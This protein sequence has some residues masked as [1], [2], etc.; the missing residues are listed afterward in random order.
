MGILN[1]V[2]G[3]V[4]LL[5]LVQGALKAK[6]LIQH[7]SITDMAKVTKASMDVKQIVVSVEFERE[8]VGQYPMDMSS[9]RVPEGFVSPGNQPQLSAF[10]RENMTSRLQKRDPSLDSWNRPYT[11]C[12][13]LV[14]YWVYSRGPDERDTI[15]LPRARNPEGDI[16]PAVYDYAG[17]V[18][19]YL[20]EDEIYVEQEITR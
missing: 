2:A 1:K 18:T 8:L 7:S 19:E 10:I 6:D 17:H 4:I 20:I 16:V 9:N 15:F 13:N 3:L 11:Y 12:Y 5:L 14:N